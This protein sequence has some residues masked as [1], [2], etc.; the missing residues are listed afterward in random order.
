M[1]SI[2]FFVL[3]V[4]KI[5]LVPKFSFKTSNRSGFIQFVKIREVV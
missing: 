4:K 3:V 5:Y 2:F 1:L